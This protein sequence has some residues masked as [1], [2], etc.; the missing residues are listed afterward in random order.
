MQMCEITTN[1]LLKWA[2]KSIISSSAVPLCSEL[3][4]LRIFWS[5]YRPGM[6]ITLSSERV[7]S[8]VMNVCLF[9]VCLSFCLSTRITQNHTAE[10]FVHVV[11]D[12]GLVLL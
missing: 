12:R 1:Y 2:R 5:G 8:N 4:P 9:V 6:I 11:C 10:L 3:V 7:R